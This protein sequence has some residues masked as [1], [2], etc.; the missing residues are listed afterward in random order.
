[1]PALG[2]V[3]LAYSGPPK[4]R[5]AIE[6]ALKSDVEGVQSVEI[7]DAAGMTK[8]ALLEL[9]KREDER[10]SVWLCYVHRIVD[11]SR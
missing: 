9:L 2:V 4:L 3:R 1:M 11:C 7:R 10:N 5:K 8:D 6:F